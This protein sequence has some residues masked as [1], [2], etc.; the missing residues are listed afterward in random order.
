MI[1]IMG[2]LFRDRRGATAI[3]YALVAGI[4]AVGIIVGMTSLRDSIISLYGRSS[5]A[6]AS[7]T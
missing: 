3:E 2:K 7:L 5:S 1:S 4:I 6:L